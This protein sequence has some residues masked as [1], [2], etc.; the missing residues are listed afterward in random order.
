MA[1]ATKPV[2]FE[3]ASASILKSDHPARAGTWLLLAETTRQVM[4]AH[5]IAVYVKTGSLL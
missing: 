5:S 3:T 2:H 1:S 4:M